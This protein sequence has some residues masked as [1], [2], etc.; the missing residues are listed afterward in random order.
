MQSII[1]LRGHNREPEIIQQGVGTK[2][3]ALQPALTLIQYCSSLS[4]FYSL[5]CWHVEQS[6]AV[7]NC[8]SKEK[9]EV[10]KKRYLY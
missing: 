7:T 4:L 6:E 10:R 8:R 3:K 2:P 5:L 9:E 1:D